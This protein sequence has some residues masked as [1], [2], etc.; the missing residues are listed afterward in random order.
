ML[1]PDVG[2][3][4]DE[5]YISQ[6]LAGDKTWEMRGSRTG[7]REVIGLIK[8]ALNTCLE[9]PNFMPVKAL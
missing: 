7:K 5:P 1:L 2:L 3:V 8:K 9:Q 6:I 4:I